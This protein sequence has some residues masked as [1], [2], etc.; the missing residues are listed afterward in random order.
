MPKDFRMQRI[1]DLIRTTL[2][3]ILLQGTEDQRFHEVTI[4]RVSV[5]RDMN[6]ARI[7]VSFMPE[8]DTKKMTAALNSAAKY[9][10]YS[11]AQSVKLRVTPE[12]RF[13]YDDS[14]AKGHRII[15]LLNK[16]LKNTG[17][18]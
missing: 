14:A 3:E 10:R 18:E 15:E 9:L 17:K 1:A 11:L 13:Y 7:Y 16:A 5:S 12:L 6:H 4:T 8:V 2:S